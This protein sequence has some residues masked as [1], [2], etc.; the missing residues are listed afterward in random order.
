[1]LQE[2][3]LYGVIIFGPLAFGAVEPW[4]LAVLEILIAS[5]LA[6]QACFRAPQGN[7]ASSRTLAAI[8]SLLIVIGGVQLLSPERMDDPHTWFR[9]FTVNAY[10]TRKEMLLYAAFGAFSWC[11]PQIIRDR[12]GLK[13]LGM[14]IFLL[15]VVVA[16]VG[17]AQNSQGRGQFI[18]G[19]REVRPDRR[20][21]GPYYNKDNAAGMLSMSFLVGCGLLAGR[22]ESWRGG[23]GIG[24]LSE[25]LSQ[26][27]LI[28]WLLAVIFYAILATHCR[29]ALFSIVSA[30]FLVGLAASLF[31]KRPG[32]RRAAAMAGIFGAAGYLWLAVKS[33]DTLGL[34]SAPFSGSMNLSVQYRAS[35]TKSAV[36]MFADNPLSG[37]GL[38]AFGTGYASYQDPLVQGIVEFA[39]NDWA[40]ALSE[41]GLLGAL[42][43]GIGLIC[44]FRRTLANIRLLG[45]GERCG[46]ALGLWA[47]VAAF[48]MHSLVEFNFQIPANAIILL[49]IVGALGSRAY[50]AP[51][52]PASG[53]IRAAPRMLRRYAGAFAAAS[54]AFFAARP[55]IA[56]FYEARAAMAT[57]ATKPYF[58]TRAIA[59]EPSPRNFL[60]L[61]QC[62]SALAAAN[63]AAARPLQRS[64]LDGAQSVLEI[65][66]SNRHAL[67]LRDW[68]L[69][70]LGRRGDYE[71]AR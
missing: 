38:G 41:F 50:E 43:T 10:A 34:G 67:R 11:C 59:W 44:L 19:L 16:V 1:M 20:P 3:L 31:V 37:V 9:P 25:F 42:L 47:A 28:G 4:S 36:Q 58:L 65:D 35:M 62:Y 6:A 63:P 15:G 60:L 18:Y 23:P 68:L 70:E 54:M 39:H 69:W 49:A 55:A 66:S 14:V 27:A 21:F 24:P 51:A 32:V 61:A 30:I 64:A 40:Q 5:L 33:P 7:P 57:D 22:F 2:S 29:G 45:P 13:R 52:P 8:F 71:T 17:I 12:D 26:Q 53:G 56:Q 46:I 48:S